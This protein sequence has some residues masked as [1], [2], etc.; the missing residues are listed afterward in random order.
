MK[1][2]LVIAGLAATVALAIPAHAQ[3]EPA[4]GEG[5]TVQEATEQLRARLG[6]EAAGRLRT[7]VDRAAERGAPA[8]PL[9]DKA[10]EGAAKG[11]PV[12][13]IAPALEAFAG[14]LERSA[15]LVGPPASADAVVAGADAL[16]RGVPAGE[17]RR[18]A[19]SAPADGRAVPLVV[20]G[21]LVEAGVPAGRAA[22]VVG[23]AVRGG[24][25]QQE[26]LRIP[27][28]VR[29]MIRQGVPPAR[30]ADRAPGPPGRGGPPGDVPAGGGPGSGAGGGPPVPPGSGPPGSGPPDDPGGS[31]G[32]SGGGPAP[33]TAG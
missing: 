10:L 5:R 11:V 19:R 4:G 22:D 8:G 28:R 9:L 7:I 14:R 6:P 25:S 29:R 24:R 32:G 16:S 2:R 23:E 3:E 17:V 33:S 13:R 31:S 26:L 18:V 15:G 21:D 30:A 1:T 12:D 20:L 27:G